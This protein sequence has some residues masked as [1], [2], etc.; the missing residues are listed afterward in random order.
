M[1]RIF[2]LEN[3]TIIGTFD[4]KETDQVVERL[5]QTWSGVYLDNDGEIAVDNDPMTE[6]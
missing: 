1:K 5:K 2:N 4:E 3:M 6:Y